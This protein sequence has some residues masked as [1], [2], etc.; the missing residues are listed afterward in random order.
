M[1]VGGN[2]HRDAQCTFHACSHLSKCAHRRLSGNCFSHLTHCVTTQQPSG[3]CLIEPRAIVCRMC[4]G[5]RANQ[6]Y[7]KQGQVQSAQYS[8]HAGW[9]TCCHF[10]V[11]RL[12]WPDPCAHATGCSP[13][14]FPD[15]N[16]GSSTRMWARPDPPSYRRT[17]PAVPRLL[18]FYQRGGRGWTDYSARPG[19]RD[20]S[21]VALQ[22]VPA[23][24]CC[25]SAD[26]T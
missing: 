2:L 7:R 1:R 20:R 16:A 21:F 3:R 18:P 19:R 25:C 4:A 24:R 13:S 10:A 15:A 9:I 17:S 8:F 6:A 11:P 5:W 14:I 26:S 23:R 22:T 12:R